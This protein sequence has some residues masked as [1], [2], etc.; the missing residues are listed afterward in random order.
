MKN[1]TKL[2]GNLNR[3]CRRQSSHQRYAVLLLII[4]LT[5]VI[6]FSMASCGNGGGGSGGNNNSNSGNNNSNPSNSGTPIIGAATLNISN[7]QVVEYDWDH[8]LTE[9]TGNWTIDD[10][11]IGGSGSISNGKLSYSVGTPNNLAGIN[12]L[13][14]ELE[15]SFWGTTF[16]ASD[17]SAKYLLLE[18]SKQN[19]GFLE[20]GEF[21]ESV[22]GNTYTQYDAF[23]YHLYVDKDVTITASEVKDSDPWT[24][25]YTGITYS[26][27]STF[28]AVKLALK[29][30]WNTV[31]F[32]EEG[33]E[34]LVGGT[35]ENPTAFNEVW[36]LTVT[37]D[38]PTSLKWVLSSDPL[39]QA[40]GTFFPTEIRF[41]RPVCLIH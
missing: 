12:D 37:M 34:T 40:G 20:K 39:L 21:K 19:G 5:A 35:W 10:D 41:Q 15:W 14:T 22:K 28:K 32:L 7:E 9:S 24:D 11:G 36:T 31:F 8:N 13:C 23:L 33:T 29:A 38:N 25:P 18:L 26:G 4:A 3:D 2:F 16:S 1:S 17:P 30:G 6:G 27:T